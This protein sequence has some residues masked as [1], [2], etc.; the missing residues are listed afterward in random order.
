MTLLNFVL[1]YMPL[2]WLS[3]YTILVTIRKQI[4]IIRKYFLW[5]NGSGRKKYHLIDWSDACL[6]KKHEGLGVLD[7]NYMNI[8]LLAKWWFRFKDPTVE[9]K[10]KYII[11]AKYNLHGLASSRLSLFWTGILDLVQFFYMRIN[12]IIGNGVSTSF[13]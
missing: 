8:A 1:T 10:W 12:R 2:Y 6:S 11:I 13:W 5:S 7:L 9:V 3:I 4:D